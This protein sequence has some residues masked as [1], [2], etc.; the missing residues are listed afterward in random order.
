MHLTT[1]TTFSIIPFVVASALPDNGNYYSDLYARDADPNKFTDFFKHVGHAIEGG[2]KDYA[3]GFKQGFER[4]EAIP[5]PNK[6]TDFFK[7]VGHSIKDG[8]GDYATGFKQGFERRDLVALIERSAEADPNVWSWVKDH[9]PKVLTAEGRMGGSFVKSMMERRDLDAR[10]AEA[11][12]NIISGA[13]NWWHKNGETVEKGIGHGEAEFMKHLM[14]REAEAEAEA[15]FWHTLKQDVPKFLEGEGRI[16][17]AFTKAM[18]ERRE[19]YEREAEAEASFV[20]SVKGWWGR[21]G[22]TVEKGI[23]HGEAEFIKHLLRRDAEAEAHAFADQDVWGLYER[24]ADLG[25][26]Y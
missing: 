26:D 2:A 1:A 9:V 23:G 22:E 20:N 4:R 13:E 5:D 6:F 16:G 7:N 18:M 14:G 21:N 17:G 24:D 10:E 12:A 19:V 3:G 25:Y 15:N 11:E 8:A